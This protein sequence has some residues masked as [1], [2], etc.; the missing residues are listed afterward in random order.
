MAGSTAQDEWLNRV[1]GV[2]LDGAPSEQGGDAFMLDER[3]GD[4]KAQLSILVNSGD[5]GARKLG[6]DLIAATKL[7]A[8]KAP[9]AAQAVDALEGALMEA[10]R[11]LRQRDTE[12]ATK[13]GVELR[14]LLIDWHQAQKQAEANVIALGDAYLQ[15]DEVRNDPRFE[16]VKEA[17][18][19]LPTII[20]QFGDQLDTDINA[21][22]NDGGKSPELVR[23]AIATIADYRGRLQGAAELS[24][25]EK[26]ASADLGGDFSVAATLSAAIEKVSLSLTKLAV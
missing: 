9:N 19:D 15:D 17:V 16:L 24:E 6:A 21:I 2:P 13:V 14:K 22:L 12:G 3:L 23:K 1:L 10:I 5:P 26:V 18:G 20:P 8:A 11:A 25:V 7:V 4:A